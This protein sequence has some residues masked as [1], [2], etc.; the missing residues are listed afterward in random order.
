MKG[1][2]RL[3]GI[4]DRPKRSRP[5]LAR[6]IQNSFVVFGWLSSVEGG[7][8]ESLWSAVDEKC[9]DLHAFGYE[10]CSVAAISIKF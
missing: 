2:R 5:H 3:I 6:L 9:I 1:E 4:V 7:N 10:S 8:W